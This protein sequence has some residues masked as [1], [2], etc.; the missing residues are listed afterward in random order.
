LGDES[1][2]TTAVGYLL[3][4]EADAVDSA[5]FQASVDRAQ[6]E[7]DAAAR[8]RLLRSAL[9][10][11]RGPALAD[12]C[13]EPFAQPLI[14]T[15]EE[16]RV[17]AVEDAVEADLATSRHTALVGELQALVREHPLR[18]RLW[19]QLMVAL[20]RGGRQSEALATYHAARQ[21][22][23]DELG[24]EPGPD[25]REIEAAILRQDAA[26]A[27]P[28]G[29]PPR[30]SLAIAPVRLRA[31]GADA[32]LV[33]RDSELERLQAVLA[34][35]VGSR[36]PA[37]VTVVGEPGVGKSRLVGEFASRVRDEVTVLSG[38]CQA[39]NTSTYAPVHALLTQVR[40]DAA[41]D[42]DAAADA[43]VPLLL[44]RLRQALDGGNAVAGRV[45]D[46]AAVGF[47]AAVAQRRPLLVVLEDIHWAQPALLDLVEAMAA[48]EEATVMMLCIARPEIAQ[49]RPEFA[50]GVAGALTV[51]LGPLAAADLRR[52]VLAVAEPG[53]V[54]ESINELVAIAD[55][56]PLFALQLV[57]SA[58]DP[59][60][61]SPRLPPAVRTL[62][63][64]RIGALAPGELA[65]VRAAA[66]AGAKFSPDAILALLP[67]EAR[68]AA[69]RHLAVLAERHLVQSTDDGYRFRHDLIR[70]TAYL[71]MDPSI[72]A[73]LHETYA[74]WLSTNRGSDASADKMVGFHLASARD[75]LPALGE[76]AHGRRLGIRAAAHFAAAGYRALGRWDMVGAANLLTR[77]VELLPPDHARRRSIMVD[78][79]GPL[80]R[81]GRSQEAA[82]MAM[83]AVEL[84]LAAG[85]VIVEWRARLE[86]AFVRGYLLGTTLSDEFL[87][88][89]ERAVAVL[90]PLGDDQG[91]AQA[92]VMIGQTRETLGMLT[93]AAAA[94]GH[95]L[96]NSERVPTNA[97]G[98]QI[99]W[100]FASVLVEGPTPVP[101][102]IARCCDLVN[103]R[104][105]PIPG[106]LIE[107]AKLHALNAD[108]DEA[109]SVLAR[110]AQIYREWGHRRG[111]IYHAVALAT[112]ELVAGAVEEAERQARRALELGAAVGGDESDVASALLLAESLVRQ[113]RL[114]EV[115]EVVRAN[116]GLTSTA[117]IGRS[118]AWNALRAD[119][120]MHHG[121]WGG[122]VGLAH[123]AVD[124]IDRT[125][126][127]TVRAELR[128]TLAAALLGS[129]NP[130][131]ARL[132]A[133]E[134][135]RMFAAKG[136]IAALASA[137]ARG[138]SWSPRT[139][140]KGCLSHEKN[141]GGRGHARH[142]AHS[143]SGRLPT[144]AG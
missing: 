2:Q 3:G 94:Y 50:S 59:V 72:R 135:V 143:R 40:I 84:A 25:L 10:L 27:V 119:V 95:A 43:T 106:V 21:R 32:G 120:R 121:S 132:V 28:P 9:S 64:N 39:E 57:A 71:A 129:G 42:Q 93:E 77:A 49:V 124:A 133:T 37:L 99:A 98:G 82:T 54:D 78:A 73:R 89:A 68:P 17:T 20:Y 46:A 103:W 76:H 126:L 96:E 36:R 80:R 111:P 137:R 7:P 19:G 1:L 70:R 138:R 63:A 131:G 101:E 31:A 104:G 92:W 29:A 8:S 113:G 125:E 118:A 44:T 41:S 109:R 69:A 141:V 18:E 117:D 23:L 35:V 53:A 90:E 60:G 67:T 122:A 116:A 6:Y 33:G 83:E 12:F 62:L 139:G 144:R 52:L 13:F 87:P 26:L 112:A 51:D 105:N 127:F 65:V 91:L 11:W 128:L 130:P 81:S 5:R 66:V 74:D 97:N 108:V 86:L 100:G 134:A 88:I 47:F 102:A 38:Q 34:G 48:H 114:D 22:L 85:D 75:N 140:R 110:V 4:V 115:E 58:G 14:S 55:G 16:L 61:S 45:I 24:V 79:C 136:N 30:T 123:G 15:L 142:R 56:S 107:L